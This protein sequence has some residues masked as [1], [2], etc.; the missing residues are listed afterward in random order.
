M[1]TITLVSS[2]GNLVGDDFLLSA[3]NWVIVGNTQPVAA[4]GFEA[5]SRG[6]TLNR[7]IVGTDDEINVQTSGASDSSLWYFQ[8]PMKYYSNFGIAYGGTISFTLGAFSGDFSMLNSLKVCTYITYYEYTLLH[9]I[10]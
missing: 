4:A 5:Y 9:N 10:S 1:G 6:P 2:G 7:Y 8:A 3:E